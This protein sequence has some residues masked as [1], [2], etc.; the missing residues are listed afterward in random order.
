M[1]WPKALRGDLDRI[2]GDLD[3]TVQISLASVQSAEIL[4]E[5]RHELI[6]GAED[7]ALDIQRLIERLFSFGVFAS[8][9]EDVAQ[10]PQGDGVLRVVATDGGA[11]NRQRIA[12]VV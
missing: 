7:I 8:L 6:A 2:L 9:S 11:E 4:L 12:L 5:R 1:G 10:V 3:R